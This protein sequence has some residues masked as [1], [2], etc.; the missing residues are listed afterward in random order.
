MSATRLQ[1]GQ[2]WWQEVLRKKFIKIM[3]FSNFESRWEMGVGSWAW[4]V[5]ATRG[6]LGPLIGTCFASSF[7]FDNN[8]WT[9]NLFAAYFC[10]LIIYFFFSTCFSCC[11]RCCC[12]AFR[13]KK[14]WRMLSKSNEI[15]VLTQHKYPK[16]KKLLEIC[17]A[18]N[19]GW[20]NAFSGCG[21]RLSPPS[22]AR[23]G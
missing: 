5:G 6:K 15:K 7:A 18:W 21:H 2:M 9:V 8:Q 14:L 12:C 19:C 16:K 20:H 13:L 10:L 23:K 1:D 4:S 11:C 3:P 17:W 22:T